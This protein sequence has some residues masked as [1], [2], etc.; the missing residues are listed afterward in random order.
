MIELLYLI[1]V[2][3]ALGYEVGSLREELSLNPN[4]ESEIALAFI[5][6]L[7]SAFLWPIVGMFELGCWLAKKRRSN[8]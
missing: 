6:C 7:M 3:V 1:G 8:D 4:D 5:A 2:V